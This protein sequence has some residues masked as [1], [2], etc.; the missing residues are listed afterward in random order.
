MM[1]PVRTSETSGDNHFI[2]Q[3][4]PEDNSE[5]QYSWY[6]PEKNKFCISS[7]NRI[8]CKEIVC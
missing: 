4:I 2:R 3:Y 7:Y 1:E 5:H 6:S 8:Y